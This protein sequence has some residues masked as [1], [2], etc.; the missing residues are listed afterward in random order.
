MENA[1]GSGRG[2]HRGEVTPRRPPPQPLSLRRVVRDV[3]VGDE[4]ERLARARL[5]AVAAVEHAGL[6]VPLDVR[7]DGP[8]V[9]VCA[10]R[11]AAPDLAT[12]LGDG[13]DD[14][15]AWVWLVA[16]LADALAALHAAGLAHGD[17]SPGNVLVG[18]RP[19]LVDLIGPALGH[20]HGT[21][22]F[23]AP[24][25]GAAADAAAADVFALG[26]LARHAAGP[27]IALEARAW[28]EP[29]VARD[30]A[31]RPSAAAVAEGIRRCASPVRWRVPDP[32]TA[33]AVRA[34]SATAVTER[35][36]RAWAWRARRRIV[37]VAVTVVA[38]AA[39]GFLWHELPD[40][41]AR[42]AAVPASG[43]TSVASVAAGTPQERAVTVASG[44]PRAGDAADPDG[45]AGTP[46]PADD[47]ARELTAQRFDALR[48]GDAEA[49]ARLAVPGSGAWALLEGQAGLLADGAR[50]I[51]LPPPQV[52]AVVLESGDGTAL[53]EVTTRVGAHDAVDA[54]GD[55]VTVAA[56]TETAVLALVW[57]GE[58]WRVSAVS[59]AP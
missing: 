27:S 9:Q 26:A 29:L 55:S 18:E 48:R 30:P 22:G 43:S 38:A 23:R 16:G 31:V 47:A 41:A 5:A 58:R 25:Q 19:L 13:I 42:A 39:A 34:A 35:D 45:A 32:S 8:V 2:W 33:D 21:P 10:P 6:V 59:A 36:P 44:K 15:G 7:R 4:D 56:T 40:D 28:T 51:D 52:D 1:G 46:P 54:D 57:S 17:V 24:E 20:E 37:P 49:L 12:V 53:V 14:L 50:L 11:I 3:G